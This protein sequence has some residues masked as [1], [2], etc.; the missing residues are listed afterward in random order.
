MLCCAQHDMAPG[1]LS[2]ST[3][4]TPFEGANSRFEGL[5]Q[6]EAHPSTV[7]MSRA[8]LIPLAARF[9]LARLRA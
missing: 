2:I 7:G 6:T 5:L 4:L 9:A 1:C 3:S 8:T